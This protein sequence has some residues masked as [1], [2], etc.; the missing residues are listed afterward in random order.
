ME[1]FKE[2]FGESAVDFSKVKSNIGDSFISI[3]SRALNLS[4]T[5]HSEVGIVKRRIYEIYG[6]EGTGK[7]TLALEAIASCQ[8]NG[9]RAMMVDA[10]HQLD[11]IYA[12]KLGVKLHLLDLGEPDS[13]EEAFDMIEWGIE[14]GEDLIVI[15]SVS[16]MTPTAE[17]EGEMGDAHMG[18]QARLMGQGLRRITSKLKA[19]V[20]TAIIFINQ[21][22]MKIGVMF[23]NPE[24][25][26]GGFALKFFASITIDLRT[27]RMKKIV[28]S[29]EEIGKVIVAKTIKNKLYPPFKKCNVYLT[30]GKGID[31]GKDLIEALVQVGAAEGSKKRSTV[32][33][34]GFNQMNRDTFVFKMKKD[35]EF[36]KKIKSMLNERQE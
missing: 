11:P 34:K 10:E 9:G 36:S 5:G 8:R 33:I 1:E 12:K 32:K 29:K 16:A 26:S 22:R 6:P 30:Y 35:K 13:G 3:G 27:P 18:L 7:T 25:R 23:G 21:I 4:L 24:T 15:D 20:P 14:Q 31:K 2:R 28:E 19:G 17:I